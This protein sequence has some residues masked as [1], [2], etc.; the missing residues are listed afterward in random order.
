MRTKIAICCLSMLSLTGVTSCYD[1]T[2][3]NY[4][5]DGQC[6]ALAGEYCQKNPG[7]AECDSLLLEQPPL[8]QE[9]H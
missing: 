6:I 3:D 9:D 4:T 1:C 8:Y 2:S 5:E 7:T